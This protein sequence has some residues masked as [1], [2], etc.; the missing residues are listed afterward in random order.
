M[1]HLGAV[2]SGRATAWQIQRLVSVDP[3]AYADSVFGDRNPVLLDNYEIAE[4]FRDGDFWTQ[5]LIRRMAD[6]LGRA[7]AAIH[8]TMGTERFV[9]MGGFAHAL[10]SDY[11]DMLAS[12]ADEASWEPG[13]DRAWIFELGKA[14]DD[15]GLIG[16]GRLVTRFFSTGGGMH[17]EC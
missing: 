8:L 11:L 17:D 4:A 6:P 12:A 9:V 10:G 5:R 7:M 2:A 14:G 16:A 15:A 13:R 3:A 1:G